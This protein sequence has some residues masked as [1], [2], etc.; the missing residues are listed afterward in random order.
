[1]HIGSQSINLNKHDMKYLFITLLLVIFNIQSSNLDS[2]SI[3][4]PLS[5]GHYSAHHCATNSC[6][7]T[8]RQY[9]LISRWSLDVSCMDSGGNW[10]STTYGGG[11]VYLGSLCGGAISFL[12]DI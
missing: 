9:S 6:S 8:L 3:T 12:S 11:G 7:V 4:D 5:Y 1:M 2:Q 10:T